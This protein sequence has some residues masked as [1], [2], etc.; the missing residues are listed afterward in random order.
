MSI[1]LTLARSFQIA[2]LFSTKLEKDNLIGQVKIIAKAD[3]ASLVYATA[4]TLSDVAKSGLKG[5]I[6]LK[7]TGKT[8]QNILGKFTEHVED[9][10]KLDKTLDT[11][12]QTV[13]AVKKAAPEVPSKAQVLDAITNKFNPFKKF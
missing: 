8:A 6:D 4:Q 12:S 1:P 13:D 9:P 5:E 10:N 2:R 7:N 3:K 11:V